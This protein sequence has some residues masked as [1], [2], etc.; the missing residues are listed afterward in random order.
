VHWQFVD[1]HTVWEVCLDWCTVWED[2]GLVHCVGGLWIGALCGRP[3]WIGALCGRSVWIG[4]LT[5]WEA[6][7][8]VHCV[9]GL[10]IGALCQRSVDWCS[11]WQACGPPI[12]LFFTSPLKYR[13][14][15][16]QMPLGY[17]RTT[18]LQTLS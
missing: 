18:F 5:V 8:L 6:C 9:G 10:W 2:C 1:W 4:V 13:Y 16:E 3:V 7:G 11:V 15:R 12:C 17:D 14:R